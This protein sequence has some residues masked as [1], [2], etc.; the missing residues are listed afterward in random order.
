MKK[1]KV[2]EYGANRPITIKLSDKYWSVLWDMSQMVGETPEEY[3]KNAIEAEIYMDLDNP[4][5]FCKLLCDGLRELLDSR[6]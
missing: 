6:K 2:M 4:E 5:D 3:C 1:A